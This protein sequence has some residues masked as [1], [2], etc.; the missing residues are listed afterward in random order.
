MTQEGYLNSMVGGGGAMS[1]CAVSSGLETKET[2]LLEIFWI[3]LLFLFKD[4]AGNR[5]EAGGEQ[6]GGKE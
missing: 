2:N 4:N 1:N 3:L 5:K 6:R